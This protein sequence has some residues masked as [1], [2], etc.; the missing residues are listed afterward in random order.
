MT[1]P[2]VTVTG[3]VVCETPREATLSAS[4]PRIGSATIISSMCS[5]FA[6][7]DDLMATGELEGQ[8]AAAAEA[9]AE[10]Y[11]VVEEGGI[12]IGMELDAHAPALPAVKQPQGGKSLPQQKA[13]TLQKM[14]AFETP[15]QLDVV[16]FEESGGIIVD[17]QV[18]P[19]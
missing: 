4:L 13:D 15:P 18:T 2:E 7:E 11:A 19:R 9:C 8:K 16:E 5:E 6:P 14:M 17:V 10:T 12:V 3:G 1:G